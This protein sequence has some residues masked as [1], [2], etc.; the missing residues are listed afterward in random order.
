MNSEQDPSTVLKNL[1]ES[2]STAKQATYRHIVEAI[3]FSLKGE[4]ERGGYNKISESPVTRKFLKNCE[5]CFK[6]GNRE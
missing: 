6:K 5:D 2:K 4:R 3:V 1:L